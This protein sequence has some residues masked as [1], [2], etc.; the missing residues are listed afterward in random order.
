MVIFHSYVSL[1]EGNQQF[2]GLNE[3]PEVQTV[4]V[5]SL[6]TGASDRP[7]FERHAEL[8]LPPEK[9]AERCFYRR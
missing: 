7:L 9:D 3:G 6:S 5:G 8:V 1:P 2:R 4:A